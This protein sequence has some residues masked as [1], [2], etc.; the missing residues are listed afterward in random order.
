M[1]FR[2]S[3]LVHKSHAICNDLFSFE[4]HDRKREGKLIKA[5]PQYFD[6]EMIEDYEGLQYRRFNWDSVAGRSAHQT[7]IALI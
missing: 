3:V 7:G 6:L 4:Y 2:S 1:G 5:T